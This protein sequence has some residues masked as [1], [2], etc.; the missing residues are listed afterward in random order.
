MSIFIF[1]FRIYFE[2]ERIDCIDKVNGNSGWIFSCQD[3]TMHDQSKNLESL[4]L[5]QF[6]YC[7]IIL[8]M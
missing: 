4:S 8:R 7:A 5:A 1:T 2:G 3:G 6:G